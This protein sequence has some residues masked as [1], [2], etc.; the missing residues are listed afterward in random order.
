MDRIYRILDPRRL[1]PG[2]SVDRGKTLVRILLWSSEQDRK[3][4][5]FF[6]NSRKVIRYT[7]TEDMRTDEG[8]RLALNDIRM[9]K[10]KHI[11]LGGSLPCTG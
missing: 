9:F 1:R 3:P 5:F 4:D 8:L 11:T 7:E 2:H 6:D 10:G